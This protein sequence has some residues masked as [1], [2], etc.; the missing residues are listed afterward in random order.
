MFD[1]I[2][3]VCGPE[4]LGAAPLTVAAQT[5]PAA[6]PAQTTAQAA[7]AAQAPR[8]HTSLVG[9][10][11]PEADAPMPAGRPAAPAAPR[12]TV[13]AAPPS[14]A[15]AAVPSTPFPRHAGV[16][17]VQ[18][19]AFPSAAESEQALGAFAQTAAGQAP[20]LS[21][22]IEPARVRGVLYYRAII[23]GFGSTAEASALCAAIKK[24]GGD[25]FVRP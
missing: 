19:A 7:Q 1:V 16:G 10:D 15:P 25:C 23:A 4:R 22:R 13:A 14:A 6:P 17:V 11:L 8:H 3:A 12:T 21:R 9:A 2:G 24:A 5:Q 18:I 20:G